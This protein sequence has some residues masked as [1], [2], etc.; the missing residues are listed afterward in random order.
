MPPLSR[1]LKSAK[2]LPR[3]LEV[4]GF[5]V[6]LLLGVSVTTVFAAQISFN[7]TGLGTGSVSVTAC[8]GT[9]AIDIGHSY[10]TAS[11]R[12][13]VSSITLSSIDVACAAKTLLLVGY[14]G[15]SSALGITTTLPAIAGWPTNSA[16][17]LAPGATVP[18]TSISSTAIEIRD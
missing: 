15:T 2:R 11:T 5:I 7:S 16:F 18:S 8:D 6:G 17:T 10:Q 1:A 3:W 4:R 13:T 14:S 12:F 9:I